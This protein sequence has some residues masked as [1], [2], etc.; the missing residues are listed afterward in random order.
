M[1]ELGPGVAGLAHDVGVH[2][3]GL[4]QLDP[5]LPDGVGLAHRDPH[6]RGDEVAALDALGHVLGEGDLR[7]GGLGDLTRLLHQVGTREEAA[8]RDDAEVEP[9]LG[10][11]DEIRVAHVE[12]GIAQVGEGHS[13]ERLVAV[14]HHGQEV[15]QQLGGMELVR[16]AVPDRHAGVLRKLLDHDLAEAPV[17]DPLV[18]AT[19]DAGG[20]LDRLLLPHLA[21]GRAEI[22]DVGALV[23]CGN[24]EGA[25]RARRVLL[26]DQG[27]VLA[28]EALLLSPRVSSLLEL[29]REIEQEA[30]LPGGEVE[31]LEEAPVAKVDGHSVVTPWKL[32]GLVV[33]NT[34]RRSSSSTTSRRMT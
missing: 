4:E 7:P 5:L 21:A 23:E 16:Q 22:G 15:G 3:V 24:L 19:E 25:A 14:L 2:L 28:P 29:E 30:K 12:P 26:E 18:V 27:D 13:V 1:E 20:V 8:R 34:A 10:G 9:H 31:L 11:A 33:T 17:L 32:V 6:V